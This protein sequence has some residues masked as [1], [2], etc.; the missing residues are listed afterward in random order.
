[1]KRRTLKDLVAG[2]RNLN[3]QSKQNACPCNLFSAKEL[4]YLF[5]AFSAELHVG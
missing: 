4:V 2:T 5:K 3:Y 1:M